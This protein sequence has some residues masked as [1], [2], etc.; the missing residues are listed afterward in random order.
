[1]ETFSEEKTKL[2]QFSLKG[3]VGEVLIWA[4]IIIFF[5]CLMMVKWFATSGHA[6]GKLEVSLIIPRFSAAMFKPAVRLLST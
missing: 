6:G 2:C 3:E 1:M 5:S 4:L